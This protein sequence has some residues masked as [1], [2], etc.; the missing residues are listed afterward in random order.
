[1]AD[2]RT[3][4]GIP[5]ADEEA[6]EAPEIDPVFFAA[7][8]ATM[9]PAAALK[10]L[11]Q[12]VGSNAILGGVPEVAKRI[13]QYVPSPSARE[14]EPISIAV[15][16]LGMGKYSMAGNS[17]RGLGLNPTDYGDMFRYASKN[18]PGLQQ[19][20]KAAPNLVEGV[21]KA[22]DVLGKTPTSDKIKL[23]EQAAKRLT[24]ERINF[25]IDILN[26]AH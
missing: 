5:T 16:K 15:D 11:A 4:Q 12:Q 17:V 22:L 7:L 23:S 26:D 13:S 3:N 14:M 8:G 9:G 18:T 21:S 19:L 20:S 6:L 2:K 25:I 1:M 10:Q 24:Q